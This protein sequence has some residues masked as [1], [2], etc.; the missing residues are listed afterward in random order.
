MLF[1]ASCGGFQTGRYGT[2]LL[3]ASSTSKSTELCVWN[4]KVPE[5]QRIS[6]ETR[7]LDLGNDC[8][9]SY[10]IMRDGL[11]SRGKAHPKICGSDLSRVSKIISTGNTFS[12][13]VYANCMCDRRQFR[14]SWRIATEGNIYLFIYLFYLFMN[15]Y[16][17]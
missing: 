12:V 1:T 7:Q 15:V 14:A 10:I 17:G 16:P 6:L 4:I 3:P 8:S 5:G 2:L 11:G 9:K 13:E